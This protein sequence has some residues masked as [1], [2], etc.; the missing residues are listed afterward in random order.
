MNARRLSTAARTLREPLLI[1]HAWARRRFRRAGLTEAQIELPSASVHCW[2]A[3]EDERPPLL[4]LMGFGASVEWQFHPNVR[5]LAR[6]RRLIVPDLL[7]FGGTVARGTERTIDL[8]VQ[9]MVELLDHLGI[10]RADVAGLSYGGFVALGLTQQHIARVDRTILIASPGQAMQPEDYDAMC[11]RFDVECMSSVLM[12]REPDGVT[13][14]MKIAWHNP[15]WIPKRMLGQVHA[16]LFSDRVEHKRALLA[17]LVGLFERRPEY[18]EPPGPVLLVWGEHDAIFP[19][20][21]GHRLRRLLGARAQMTVLKS[22][23]HAP[24]LEHPRRFNRAVSD[25]LRG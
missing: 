5:A 17:D 14:L 25:F 11:R 15:P 20:E 9:V 7:Y 18:V 16:H 13:T 22:A 8:Q 23:A 10:E 2:A 24:Q 4:L 1:Q 21:V 3:Q 12:P 19:V 6:H